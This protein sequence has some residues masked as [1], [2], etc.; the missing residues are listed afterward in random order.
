MALKKEKT[1]VKTFLI[2]FFIVIKINCSL[3]LQYNLFAINQDFLQHGEQQLRLNTVEQ[4]VQTV[5]V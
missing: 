4:P 3:H 1:E 2:H 5:A